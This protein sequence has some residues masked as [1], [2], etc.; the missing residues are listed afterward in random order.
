MRP[1]NY[2]G[3]ATTVQWTVT[4]QGADVWAGTRYW[5][6]IVYFCFV[7]FW[8]AVAVRALA[9]LARLAG[10]NWRDEVA[11]AGADERANVLG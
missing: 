4:N 11:V 8:A 6:D 7:I 3:E 5:L 2:S 10:H 9:K 1:T